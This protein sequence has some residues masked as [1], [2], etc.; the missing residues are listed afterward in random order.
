MEFVTDL[1]STGA[2]TDARYGAVMDRFGERGIM[3][4]GKAP[5]VTTAWFRWC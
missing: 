1:L 4:L 3:D 5:L 2:V